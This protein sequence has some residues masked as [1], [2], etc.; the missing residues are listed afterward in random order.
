MT[1]PAV[2]RDAR[3]AHLVST[4]AQ[5]IVE[6]AKRLGLQWGAT[7]AT[8]HQASTDNGFV[9]LVFDGDTTPVQAMSLV[10]KLLPGWRVMVMTVPPSANFVIGSL[11]QS[12]GLIAYG[13]RTTNTGT[14]TTT[15]L[16]VLS[17]SNVNVKAG[18]AYHIYSSAFIFDSSVLGDTVRATLRFTTDG[19]AAT[20]T[21]T[22][23][24]ASELTVT[25][26]GNQARTSLSK[27]Y[28]P[29]DDQ[30]LNIVMTVVRTAGTGSV[31][32]QHVNGADIDIAVEAIGVAVADTGAAL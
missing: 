28:L 21:S 14:T 30:L 19:T 4:G 23:L 27:V 5:A 7:P 3:S 16:A 29:S 18:V 2:H 10:G 9:Q 13:S 15:E 11:V 22:P 32:L 8:I 31:D 20:I 17:L 25:G 24:T 26:G 12:S 6:N 1:A